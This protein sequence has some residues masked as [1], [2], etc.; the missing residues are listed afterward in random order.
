MPLT[1]LQEDEL[2][3][4]SPERITH[5]PGVDSVSN[6]ITTVPSLTSKSRDVTLVIGISAGTCTV[7]GGQSPRY[8][9]CVPLMAS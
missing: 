9:N 5:P 1:E 4:F 2:P 6:D 8:A 7:G 3:R